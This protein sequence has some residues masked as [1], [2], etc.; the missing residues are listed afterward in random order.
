MHSVRLVCADSY[1]TAPIPDVDPT[2]SQ[3]RG[4]DIKQV[5]VVRIFGTSPAGK[6]NL[7]H[8]CTKSII[9]KEHLL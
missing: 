5:P 8:N 3:F 2:F 7:P 4:S 6:L 1:Q 9:L